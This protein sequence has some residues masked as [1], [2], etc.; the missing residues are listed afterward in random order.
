MSKKD[1]FNAYYNSLGIAGDPDDNG[2]MSNMCKGTTAAFNLRAKT[3]TIE[4][5]RAHSGYVHS[6]SGRL[7]AFSMIANNFDGSS[8]LIDKFHEKVMI[9]LAELP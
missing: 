6:R 2:Y 1:I 8:R 4:R 3:G 5:V 9:Q 7:I